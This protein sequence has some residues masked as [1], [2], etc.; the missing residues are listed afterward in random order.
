MQALADLWAK[1]I[2]NGKRDESEIKVFP[3]SFQDS[4][5]LIVN[6]EREKVAVED[7]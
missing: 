7:A 2:L 5:M 3:Q 1:Y 4:I 6:S